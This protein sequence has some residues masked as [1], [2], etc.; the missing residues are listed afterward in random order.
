MIAFSPT[1]TQG[2]I[3][4]TRRDNAAERIEQIAWLI[5]ENRTRTEA[6]ATAIGKVLDHIE[7]AAKLTKANLA[8]AKLPQHQHGSMTATQEHLTVARATGRGASISSHR[9]P[10]SWQSFSAG[11]RRGNNRDW[12]RDRR[13]AFLI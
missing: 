9:P 2:A 13:R 10:C 7:K 5:E 1:P 11:R 12:F 3:M 4:P 6:T 8:A